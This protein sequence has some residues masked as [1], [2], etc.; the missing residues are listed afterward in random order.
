MGHNAKI[1]QSAGAL[2]YGIAVIRDT[3]LGILIYCVSAVTKGSSKGLRI[4]FGIEVC[5]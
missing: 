1:P 3:I 4:F 2:D 5:Q